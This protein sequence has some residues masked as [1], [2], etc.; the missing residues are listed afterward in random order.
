M[1]RSRVRIRRSVSILA[2]LALAAAGLVIAATPAFAAAPVLTSLSP[3]FGSWQGGTAD[4]LTGS[5]FFC[6]G[7]TVNACT[8]PTV[9]DFGTFP[10]GNVVVNSDTSINVTAPDVT[11]AN[12]GIALP[13][14]VTN[15]AGTSTNVVNFVNGN[16]RFGDAFVSSTSTTFTPTTAVDSTAT[17]TANQWANDT[18]TVGGMMSS[19]ATTYTSTSAT[20]ATAN[21]ATNEWTGLV[22]HSGANTATVASNT[23]NTMTTSAWAPAIPAAAATFNIPGNTA[24]VVSNTAT[25][26]TLQGFTSSASTT[27]TATSAT[28]STATWTT[29]Q[30]AGFRVNDGANF[31]SVISN[32]ATVLTTTTWSAATPA[33]AST[34][35]M[36]NWSAP[37]GT[38]SP[39]AATNHF[40]IHSGP[41]NGISVINFGVGGVSVGC[42]H[43][44][45]AVG[46]YLMAL[47]SPV[48]GS[49]L[50]FSVASDE[51]LILNNSPALPPSSSSDINGSV[52]TIIPLPAKTTGGNP[53]ST[54]TNGD[55]VCPPTP[56]QVQ[57]GLLTCAVAVAN[58]SGTNFGAALLESPGQPSPGAPTLALSATGVAN[59]YSVSGTGWW[60][61]GGATIPAD[62]I[63]VGCTGTPCT[64]GTPAVSSNVTVTG[65]S[66]W[67]SCTGVAPLVCTD[68]IK[69]ATISGTFTTGGQAG[70]IAVDQPDVQP[71]PCSAP[72]NCFPGN[73]PIY[74]TT[75]STSTTF[76]ATTATDSA[77]NYTANQFAG[78]TITDGANS[79]T[80]LSNTTNT[81]TL[82]GSW[83]PGTPANGTTFTITSAP[84]VEATG[85]ATAPTASITSA[86]GTVAWTNLGVTYAP[87]NAILNADNP[88]NPNQWWQPTAAS[89][90]SGPV[91]L[92][93]NLGVATTVSAVTTD[94]H[95]AFAAPGFNIQTS[96][97]CTTFTT[98]VTVPAGGPHSRTDAFLGGQVS[99]LCLRL[100]ITSFP[101]T[102]TPY[103][104]L[105]L[106]QLGWDNHGAVLPQGFAGCGG[107]PTN[108][109]C[110]AN[111][112]TWNPA[113][114]NGDLTPPVITA[115]SPVGATGS[116]TYSYVATALNAYGETMASTF[117][118]TTTGNASLAG[119][120]TAGPANSITIQTVPGATSYNLYGRAATGTLNLIANIPPPASGGASLT[121][122]DTGTA[123]TPQIPPFPGSVPQNAVANSN[124]LAVSPST[125]GM[126]WQPTAAAAAGAS[127]EVDLGSAQTLASV[128]PIWFLGFT[129]PLSYEI[130]TSTNGQT[131]TPQFTTTTNTAKNVTDEFPGGAVSASYFRIVLNAVPATGAPYATVALS[132]VTFNGSTASVMGTPPTSSLFPQAY[133]PPTQ[134]N[135]ATANTTATWQNRSTNNIFNGGSLGSAVGPSWWQTTDAG[136]GSPGNLILGIDLGTQRSVSTV[137]TSWLGSSACPGHGTCV[138]FNAVTYTI[139]TSPDGVTWTQHATVASFD[140]GGC[141]PGPCVSTDALTG[142]PVAGVRYIEYW[143]TAWN[144]T[145]PHEGYGP[146]ANSVVVT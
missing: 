95:Q 115:V 22:V 34:F 66:Y 69:K 90:G 122:C 19:L 138:G 46:S 61:S 81:L 107:T 54:A 52:A 15:S 75:S 64:G 78:Q 37:S 5:G 129:P 145:T 133:Y 140:P 45:A 114:V 98:Q 103:A 51:S 77:A 136:T 121:F 41:P 49:V 127:Y 27:F 86:A 96:P 119:G 120:C 57:Q 40:V 31:A 48:A 87:A 47:T 59:T 65:G 102:A 117:K 139:W 25:S 42:T 84:T 109:G 58:I 101:A 13:V 89:A 53:P 29:N 124:N 56:A 55:G 60:G 82:S 35:T 141:T 93:V 71:T 24:Q 39:P 67:I 1:H 43:V 72:A 20:D 126:F 137:K 88:P 62:H 94:W 7:G 132:Q 63:R 134:P 26:L 144:A 125:I 33:A 80:V 83:S 74:T 85:S 130:D 9:V 3:G 146:A 111:T 142:G 116:T 44:G 92:T 11:I 112:T 6:G 100:D 97:D 30:W 123:T 76:T 38:T 12:A 14:T 110:T 128:T 28:D 106:I 21:W 18:V 10:G 2:A 36:G 23:A 91:D 8:G 17:W 99:A 131:W 16:C 32:T 104:A 73:G 113:I 4:V 105:A 50:P 70:T 68:Q 118:Q 79:G 135:S 143:I 108:A